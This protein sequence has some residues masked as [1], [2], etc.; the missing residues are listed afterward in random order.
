VDIAS[1]IALV[2]F[3]AIIAFGAMLVL[4][5]VARRMKVRDHLRKRIGGDD[6]G[7]S[8]LKV[9]ENEVSELARLLTESGLGWSMS[10]FVTRMVLATLS[11][12]A[13]G[14]VLG[15]VA[16]ALL[17]GAVGVAVF[18][19]LARQAR[20]R[21]LALCDQQMP[22]ALEIV[23]LALRAGHPLPKALAIAAAEAPEPIAVELQRAVD[24]QELGRPIGDVLINMGQRLPESEA[25]HTFMT[26]VLVLQQTGGN[27]ISVID[28]I[29]ENARAR[30]QYRAKLRALTAEGRASAKML[31]LMPPAFAILAATVD[32][33]YGETLF[34]TTAGNVVLAVTV[35]LWLL[36][37]LWTRRLVKAE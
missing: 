32:P 18:P 9:H 30:Q 4:A 19:V 2:I 11:G 31:A 7:M 33:T 34:F 37:I 15:G 5:R 14:F 21:R 16:L 36:G 6:R 28:R 24:E 22:Q 20:D 25:V 27:L 17:L 26:A 12:I 3:F 13:L 10:V 35:G 1:Q 29:I 23:T 8:L